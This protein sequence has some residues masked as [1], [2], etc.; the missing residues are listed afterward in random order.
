VLITNNVVKQTGRP[1]DVIYPLRYNADGTRRRSGIFC[2]D[3]TVGEGKRSSILSLF[4]RGR[5]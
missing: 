5:D 3:G 4:R 2:R 1:S